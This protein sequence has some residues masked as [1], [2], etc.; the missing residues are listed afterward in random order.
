MGLTYQT[1]L[2]FYTLCD[3]PTQAELDDYYAQK[4]FQQ[5]KSKT[6]SVSYSDQELNLFAQKLEQRYAAICEQRDTTAY[7]RFLDVGCGE[8]F[9]LSFFEQ[10]GY[11]VKGL[12][13]SSAGI[14]QH[15]PEL[16]DKLVEGDVFKS[17]QNELEL[18]NKY[19]IIWLQNVL[20]HVLEPVDLLEDL[21]GLLSKN[22][23]LVIT[24]PNDFSELQTYAL[25]NSYVDSEYW[26]AIPDHISYFNTL[27]INEIIEKTGWKMLDKLADFPIDWFIFNNHSNYIKNKSVGKEGHFARLTIES[28][29]SK[30][31]SDKANAFYR[32]LA[33]L[34]MGRNTTVIVGL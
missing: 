16:L 19:E 8:G 34:G 27:N 10:R 11:Q 1:E 5:L 14:K 23:V 26:V 22:G 31:G 33:D 4:Y 15:H 21:K 18:K 28:L 9:A 13:Y 7:E 3:K 29:I 30:N 12:D 6:Y 20:E 2:G 24:V 17:L 25:N 32:S